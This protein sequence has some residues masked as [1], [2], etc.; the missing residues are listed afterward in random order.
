VSHI[1]RRYFSVSPSLLPHTALMGHDTNK[2]VMSHMW[3]SHY[4]HMNESCHTWVSHVALMDESFLCVSQSATTYIFDGSWNPKPSHVTH[5]N[6]P[7]PWHTYEWV[8]SHMW[9]SH[10]HDTHMN[11]SCHTCEQPMAM[12]HIWMR[13]VTHEWDMSH[14]WTSHFP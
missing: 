3:T 6:T 2:R 14:T 10:G 9:T 1:W 4:T 8:M 12:T 7:W 13:H 5:V 11:E